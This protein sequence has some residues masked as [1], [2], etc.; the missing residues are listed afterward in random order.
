MADVFRPMVNGRRST[1]YY[2]KVRDPKTRRWTKVSL[3]VTDKGVARERLRE[4]QKRTEQ[5]AYGLISPVAEMGLLEHLDRFER[6]LVQKDRS[7]SYRAQTFREIAKVALFCTGQA[8]PDR[9]SKE[10][11]PDIRARL[12]DVTL[13]A[14]TA[15]RVDDFLAGLP[16]DMAARTRNGFRAA[17]ISFFSFLLEKK[18]LPYNPLLSTTRQEGEKKR[19]RRALPPEQLQRLLDAAKVRPLAHTLT[20]HRG[21][22]KGTQGADV[23]AETRRVREGQGAHR[24]LIYLTAVLTGLRRG[25]L[26]AL[27]VKH[28]SLRSEVAAIH[29]PG[30]FTKNGKDAHL[31]LTSDLAGALIELVNGRGPDEPV[32]H[33]PQY[34][35]LLRAFKKDLAHAGIPYRDDLGRVFDFHSL[36]K[37][38]GSYLRQAKVDPAV[39]RLYMRHGDIR[40]TMEIYNDDRLHDLHAEAAMKLPRFSL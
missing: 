10:Q 14:I 37:C 30:D 33:I 13:E 35:E 34:D 2:G 29:L 23:S 18:K 28:L 12:A 11:I 3:G 5:A 21:S 7:E 24:A 25:E 40:L 19:V 22:R 32:F 4:L 39:S 1:F 17:V 27:R 36:R 31:P 8:I 26:R 20:I 6:H 16:T 15:D 38:L 9:I